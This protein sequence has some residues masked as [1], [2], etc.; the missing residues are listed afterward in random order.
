[1]NKTQKDQLKKVDALMSEALELLNALAIEHRE[2]FD[3]LSEEA[4]E[5]EKGQALS[6]LADSLEAARD[7]VENAHASVQQIKII[8]DAK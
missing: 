8:T 6:D 1:V 7:E 4:Q 2:E 5:S 3:G